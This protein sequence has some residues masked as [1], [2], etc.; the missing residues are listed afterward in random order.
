MRVRHPWSIVR[1]PTHLF[2]VL[3]G[4]RGHCEPRSQQHSKIRLGVSQRVISSARSQT[5]D[6]SQ[7]T[8]NS[9]KIRSP[10]LPDNPHQKNRARLV[11][12]TG[13]QKKIS[14]SQSKCEPN[15]VHETI[16]RKLTK[17]TILKRLSFG[18][19][20][21]PSSAITS[22]SSSNSNSLPARY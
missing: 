4:R 19:C 20:R 9:M 11:S 3:G 12:N 21:F 1:H 15:R 18:S 17:S 6:T 5:G 14:T 2:P 22:S 16:L 8:T 13:R 10:L 7:Q